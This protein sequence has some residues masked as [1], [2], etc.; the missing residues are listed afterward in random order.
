VAQTIGFIGGTGPEGKGLAARFARAGM[1]VILGSRSTE[2]GEEAA[3]DVLSTSGGNVRGA[4]NE[5]TARESDIVVLTVPFSGLTDTLEALVEPIGSK[6]V[7]S[8]VVPLLFAKGRVT[9]LGIEEG[10]ASELAQRIL[11]DAKVVGAYHNL[12]AGHLIDVD[13]AMEGDVLVCGDDAEAV[14]QVIWLSEQIRDLRGVNCGPLSSSHYI[15]G[16]TA[17]LININRNYK[18]ESGV[19]IVGI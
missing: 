3:K 9:M 18:K 1:N 10:S 6:V 5:V 11:P 12:A 2:R 15:E 16:V 7:V 8:A 14:R 13:H 17:L 4:T 19:Q